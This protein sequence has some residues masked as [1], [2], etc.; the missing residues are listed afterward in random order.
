P[1]KNGY[2]PWM[3]L[4]NGVQ[5]PKRQNNYVVIRDDVIENLRLADAYEM[6]IKE[7][8]VKGFVEVNGLRLELTKTDD[9]ETLGRL[10]YGKIDKVD[11]DKYHIDAYRY[12][13]II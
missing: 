2:W 8:I 3:M 5:F 12:L 11:V 1:I 4:H 9:I 7:A 6:I 10:I 13:L